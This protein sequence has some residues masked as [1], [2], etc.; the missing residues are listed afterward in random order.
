MT[1]RQEWE[2]AT[3]GSR[4]LAIAADAELRRRYRKIEPLRSAEPAPVSDAERQH[5]DLTPQQ[6]SGETTRMSGLTV[7]RQAFRAA[8]NEKGQLVPGQ[9]VTRANLGEAS[10]AWRTPWRD[11]ILHHPGRRSPHRRR[12]SG[13][14]LSMTSNTRLE[15]NHCPSRQADPD[16]RQA[17]DRGR[18]AARQHELLFGLGQY[19]VHAGLI[20]GQAPTPGRVVSSRAEPGLAHVPRAG[21][22]VFKTVRG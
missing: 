16:R 21:L 1:D 9:D 2:Q 6:S 7:Q 3:A 11:A 8:M 10:P 17:G 13:S 22:M 4:R 12:S 5:P 18:E 14:P 19:R 15:A 20:F